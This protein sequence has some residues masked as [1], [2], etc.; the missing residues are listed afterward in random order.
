MKNWRQ[1]EQKRYNKVYGDKP[2]YGKSR[3]QD[4]DRLFPETVNKSL[5][6]MDLACGAAHLSEKY[7][8]YTGVDISTEVIKRNRKE[9]NGQYYVANLGD[10]SRWYGWKYEAVFA[11]DVMEHIPK[12]YVGLVVSEISKLNS[13]AF[14]FKIHK[15]KSNHSDEQGNLHRTIESHDFWKGVLEN[16]FKVEVEWHK[17][18]TELDSRYL[19]YFKCSKK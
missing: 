7:T 17:D 19:S 18:N 8:D 11:N 1:Q 4:Y 3:F 15:G 10:L 12:E 2:N 9:C 5:T 14:Y 16:F 13:K 6:V